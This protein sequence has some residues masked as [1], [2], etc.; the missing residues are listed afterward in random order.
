MKI[1]LFSDWH[2]G[3]TKE[4]TI[5]KKLERM[6]FDDLDIL[7]NLGDNCGGLDGARSTQTIT[8]LVR[9]YFPQ[10]PFISCLGNHDYWCSNPKKSNPSPARSEENIA[11]IKQVFTEN[12]VHFLDTDGPYRQ[13]GVC[14]V[15]HS[16]WYGQDANTNDLRWMPHALDG[17]T[18]QHMRIKSYREVFEN[19]DKLLPSD[20]QIVFC[21][22]FPI[23]EFKNHL[24]ITYGGP[25]SLGDTLQEQYNIQTFL[26]GHAHQRHEGP[27]RYESGSDYGKPEYIIVPLNKEVNS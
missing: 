8:N 4:K 5:R 9:E 23:V 20:T 18:H 17:N 6:V 22:H 1:G 21:S 2:I 19:L 10:K 13:D 25:K 11:K 16:L 14:F 26:N 24:D 12:K 15:G 27:L 7:I 3:L